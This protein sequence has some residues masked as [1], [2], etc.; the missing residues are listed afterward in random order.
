MP[1]RIDYAEE[2]GKIYGDLEIT[3]IIKMPNR[4]V[5]CIAKCKCGV[6]K[7]YYYSNVRHG[8]TTSCG[9]YQSRLV[10]EMMTTHGRRHTRLYSIY[11]GMKTR[12]LNTN[13]PNY[14][15]YGKRGIKICDEWLESFSNF[16]KWSLENGY[17]D[18][19]SIDRVDNNGDYEP[20]NCRWADRI[21]QIHNRNYTWR[22][23]IGGVTKPAVV[24][25][26]ENGIKYKTAHNRKM[27]GWSDVDCV[28]VK[29]RTSM[30]EL[31]ALEDESHDA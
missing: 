13:N 25:C 3:E 9:C 20:T 19:L 1:S 10:S 12:C 24:W 5:K 27:K 11:T 21:T 23:S 18:N 28:T 26:K 6:E 31:K 17:K 16:E 2:I 15:H 29:M 14:K 22:I 7:E 4:V 30:N 8:K